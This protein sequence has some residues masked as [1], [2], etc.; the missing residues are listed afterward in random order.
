MLPIEYVPTKE[1]M[2]VYNEALDN[3]SRPTA[4]AVGVLADRIIDKKGKDVVLVSLARAGI[5]IG[6]LLKHYIKFK[7]NINVLHYS[8]SIIRG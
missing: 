1:Y 5:P 7:Y 4:L 3:Y 8:I 2:D 6:I